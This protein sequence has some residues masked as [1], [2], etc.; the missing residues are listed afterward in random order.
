VNFEITNKMEETEFKK[1]FSKER[2]SRKQGFKKKGGGKIKKHQS[3]TGDD[4]LRV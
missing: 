1:E 2:V 4:F 3:S